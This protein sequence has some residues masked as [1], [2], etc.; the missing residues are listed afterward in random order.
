LIVIGFAGL[1]AC[2]VFSLG[3]VVTTTV[4]AIT[5]CGFG[6]ASMSYLLS[7]QSAVTWQQRGVAT[8]GISFFR[9]LGGAIGIGLL[10]TMFNI[11]SAPATARL[12]NDHVT[13]DQLLD[14]I[15]RAALPAGDVVAMQHAIAGALVWVFVAMLVI[16]IF[17]IIVSV[18]MRDRNA[19]ATI[20]EAAPI[21]AAAL[22]HA[23][24]E[25][26]LG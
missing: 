9:T 19:D 21:D 6:P 2:A 12:K 1:V 4:L 10:G 13:V 22:R 17:G 3:H 20:T 18:L 26:M 14:P 7:A 24:S 16:A 11:L 23:A 15:K 25:G 5:G 8:A